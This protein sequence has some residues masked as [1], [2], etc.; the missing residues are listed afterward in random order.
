MKRP[1][2]A[3]RPTPVSR[4]TASRGQRRPDVAQS[5]PEPPVSLAE[6]RSGQAT[7]AIQAAQAAVA[8]DQAVAQ[9]VPL[10]QAG[11]LAEA[12]ALYRQALAIAP[13]ILRR[14]TCS[15]CW[16]TR[17][18]AR[19]SPLT[20]I[21]QAIGVAG[22]RP[23]YHL[24]YGAVL[25]AL[26]RLDDAVT[27]L[28]AGA[29]PAAGLP[30]GVQQPG[31]RAPGA[32]AA[33]RGDPLLRAGRH[34]GAG[35]RRG[36]LQPRR[37]PPGRGPAGPGHR[38]LPGGARA[39]PA[40]PAA[41]YNLGNALRELQRFPEAADAY[42][43]VLALD[44]SHVDAQNNLGVVLQELGERD[45]AIECFRRTIAL[46]ADY[47]KAHTNL[48]HLLRERGRFDEAI[49]EYRQALALQPDDSQAHS[50]LI[51][52]LDHDEHATPAERLAERR[53]W[54]ERHAHALT[55]PRRPP[56]ERPRSGPA[57]PRRLRLRRLLLPLGGVGV[58]AD[59][60]RPRSE[61]G[62]GRLLRH[63][64]PAGRADRALRPG[65]ADLARRDHLDRRGRRRAG[66]RR[67][68]RH[69]GRSRRALG[70][71]PAADLRAQA[72]PDP[73][74]GLGL[75]HRHRPGRDGLPAG[76]PGRRPATSRALVP[77]G[78]RPPAEHR[79]ASRPPRTC[80]TSPR[81]RSSSA[82]RHVRLVQPRHQ[83]DRPGAGPLGAGR[84]RRCRARGWSSRARAW[85]TPENRAR[86]LA[87]FAARGVE[88]RAHRDPR[89]DPELRAPRRPTG[90]STS[91]WTRSRTA[92]A[93][94][95]STG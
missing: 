44:P 21:E 91:S 15:G 64:H 77:R 6:R 26:G 86:I 14:C 67:P 23:S 76:R 38:L 46:Q 85:T 82:G 56:P 49:Q 52:V 2:K 73:G 43:A 1:P 65:R 30:R 75:R 72:G 24:N 54:N 20:L 71:R 79:S 74:H 7:Q 94:P 36:P 50:G 3:R 11:R 69:P 61:P 28:A 35:L 81:R 48:A 93:P 12:E 90:R 18:G 47:P 9:G 70:Q 8:A 37:R 87:A 19:T 22:D 78:R 51:L 27:R 89:R 68:D 34:A 33:R 83:A 13:T 16:P 60:L 62:R 55:L 10:H 84:W 59:P 41:S 92:A 57:A 95:P 53:A 17:S 39:R 88:R 32:R 80:R 45:E 40:Y 31:R 58:H 42:R 5:Q 25:Q 4:V 66:P 29:G 63:R